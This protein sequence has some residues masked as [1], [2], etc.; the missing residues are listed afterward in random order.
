MF[1][2]DAAPESVAEDRGMSLEN[3][4]TCPLPSAVLAEQTAGEAGEG[5]RQPV[6]SF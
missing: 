5:A 3:P 6:S 1:P 4:K 2:P